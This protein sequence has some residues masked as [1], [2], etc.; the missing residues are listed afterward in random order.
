MRSRRARRVTGRTDRCIAM[1]GRQCAGQIDNFIDATAILLDS[2]PKALYKATNCRRFKE[3]ARGIRVMVEIR[4]AKTVPRL[5]HSGCDDGA[6]P[7]P[8]HLPQF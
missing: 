5:A 8:K 1:L 6:I 7:P 3:N 4:A 2:V